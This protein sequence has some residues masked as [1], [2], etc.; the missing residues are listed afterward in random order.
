MKVEFCDPPQ[1]TAGKRRF[2]K[3][4]FQRGLAFEAKVLREYSRKINFV[5]KPWLCSLGEYRQPDGLFFYPDEGKIILIECKYT[6]T[7][8]AFIQMRRYM[9]WLYH[10]FPRSLWQIAP[11][12][13]CRYVDPFEKS[14]EKY[15]LIEDLSCA[16]AQQFSVLRFLP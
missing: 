3:R 2:V 7:H 9:D 11:V 12:E 5:P 15:K 13:V 6:H 14:R 8:E 16:T 4:A 10:L 1:F